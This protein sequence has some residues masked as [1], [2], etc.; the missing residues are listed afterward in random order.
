MSKRYWFKPKSFG[1]GAT[2]VTWEGWAI[3][4]GTMAV[5][6]AAILLAVFAEAHQWPNRHPLQAACLFVLVVTLIVTIAVSRDRTDGDWRW[7]W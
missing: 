4:L 2:P 5:I 6:L 3:A 1:Y 7:R